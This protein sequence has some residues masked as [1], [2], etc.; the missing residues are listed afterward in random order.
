MSSARNDLPPTYPAVP[1]SL[2]A[3]D[4]EM[5]D[6]NATRDGP[7]PIPN[8][9]PNLTPYLGLR[10]RLSQV[11]INRWTILLLLVLFR[12]LLAV[13][14]MNHDIDSARKEA[15]SACTG[16]ESM[17][18]AMASMPH[19]MSQGVNEL[20]AA[21]VTSAINGLLSM[22]ELSVTA[23][24]AIVVFYINLL[25][26]T[27]V[28]LITLAISGSLDVAMK[29]A[30]DTASFLNT[31][32]KDIG[33]GINSSV[34][35]FETTVKETADFFHVK[36]FMS[37]LSLPNV[38]SSLD[39]LE[40]LSLPSSLDEDLDKLNAS[41]PTFSQVHNATNAALEM[42]FENVKKLISGLIGHYE[43]NNSALPV[44]EK[45]QL[46]FCSDN[47]GINDFFNDLDSIANL[48]RRI[49]IAVLVILAILVCIPMA[50]REIRSWRTV[51]RRA[52]LLSQSSFDPIDVVQIASRPY[53]S[54]F[55]IKVANKF[56]SAR[57]QI[58]VR[59]F[60]AYLTSTPA[61]FVLSLAIAGLLGCLCQYILL[62]SI[63]KEIPA[64]SNQVGA[65][66][67]KVVGALN[68][69]STEWAQGTNNVID[70][71][72]NDINTHVF[73]WVNETTTALNNTLNTFMDNM[74]D[75]LNAT[76]PPDNVLHDASRDLLNCVLGL[77]VQGIEKGLTWVSD[78]A[79]VDFPTLPNN[80]FSLG[81]SESITNATSKGGDPSDSFLAASGSQATDQISNAV[82]SMTNK[83]A[84]GIHTEVVISASILGIWLAIVLIGLI[85]TA[86]LW[87][88]KDKT[89]AEGGPSY[90]YASAPPPP[91]APSY[92]ATTAAISTSAA[93][94][95]PRNP[96]AAGAA[97]PAFD[98]SPTDGEGAHSAVSADGTWPEDEKVGFAG[99][100][101]V[102][103]HAGKGMQRESSY[104]MVTVLA[105][106]VKR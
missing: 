75:A 18:S 98:P 81:A 65:F 28:C 24:E 23:V 6:Y 47:N 100:R 27:Y 99:Q 103:V 45:K 39:Q 88:R 80:T 51:Q 58:L 53:T 63:E 104:G 102:D 60:I 1:S 55:G 67:D 43:F 78:N 62:K 35:A 44:P 94:A 3:G 52:Q 15:L 49:F 20:T 34:G 10:S 106:D 83:I 54:T 21:G 66:A 40:H 69:A 101:N 4:H 33:S 85:R 2:Y 72:N 13:S 87:W 29:V 79:K 42:P 56:K 105:P 95:V 93:P 8:T 9:A 91:S 50:Y 26:Q 96:T 59:W 57:R 7:P 37:K 48:A 86:S 76:F 32:L 41:I 22:L 70:T 19:Y 5:R 73:G 12:T 61:L 77:K 11:W 97:F 84:E 36:D 17:G 74:Y 16:V 89:R 14:N 38:S 82:V 90:S 31:T 64:L 30:N 92:G 68:N 46:T 25:T 71:T